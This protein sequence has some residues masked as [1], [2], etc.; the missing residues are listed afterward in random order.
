M[1]AAFLTHNKPGEW[2]PEHWRNAVKAVTKLVDNPDH[3]MMEWSDYSRAYEKPAYQTADARAKDLELA[4][5]VE[6]KHSY[7]FR[8]PRLLQAAFHHPSYPNNWSDGI[9]SYQ[10]LEFLGDSLLDMTSIT[11]L[12][13]KYPEKDPQ[14]LTEHKMAMVSNQFLGVVCIQL[15]FHKHLCY[16]HD[17]LRLQIDSYENEINDA[18]EASHGSMDYWTT[19]KEGPKVKKQTKHKRWTID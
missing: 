17:S 16:H 2:Q 18:K 6:E 13:Y 1:G 15:E 4:R 11:H 14:W 8:Y 7:H 3:I 5:K 19:V 10:R 9:P 12:F